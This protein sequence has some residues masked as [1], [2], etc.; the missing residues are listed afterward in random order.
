MPVGIDARREMNSS[1]RHIS[2]IRGY[3]VGRTEAMIGPQVALFSVCILVVTQ[4]GRG[5]AAASSYSV[6]ILSSYP[7]RE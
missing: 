5:M 2:P 1:P 7:I 4:G 3:T 6:L